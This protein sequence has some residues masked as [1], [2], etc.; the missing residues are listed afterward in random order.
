SIT[1]PPS[2]TINNNSGSC[3]AVHNYTVNAS[4]NCS[5][6]KALVTGIPSGSN[7]PIGTTNVVWRATDASNNQ[8]TCSFNVTVQV[9]SDPSLYAAYTA[10]GETDVLMTTNKVFSGGVGNT[11]NAAKV[12]LR[13]NTEITAPTTFVK[14][15]TLDATGGSTVSTYYTGA[16]STSLLP[17]FPSFTNLCTNDVTVAPNTSQTLTGS[18]YDIVTVKNNATVTFSGNALVNVRRLIVENNGKVLFN[19]NTTLRINNEFDLGDNSQFNNVNT[20]Y[21]TLF[22]KVNMTLQKGVKMKAYV[23]TIGN[24]NTGNSNSGN[25]TI[26]TGVFIAVKITG[27][28]NTHWYRDENA[29]FLPPPA[30]Y[31]PDQPLALD[32]R[33]SEEMDVRLSPNPASESFN[34]NI[35][36]EDFEYGSYSIYDVNGRLAD[37]GELIQSTYSN[38]VDIRNLTPGYFTVKVVIDGKIFNLSLVVID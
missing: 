3:N 14:S 22:S 29:C 1:C 18:C 6:T 38:Q 37:K 32:T 26:L 31:L 4:D 10:I 25:P 34:L 16:A 30:S 23:R 15:V 7:F 33:K 27:G 12:R 5:F 24:F 8:N 35:S 11:T 19:Q 2:V 13:L 28:T 17:A 21:V 36:N 9:T 20:K